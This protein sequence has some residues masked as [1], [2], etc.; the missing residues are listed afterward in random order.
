MEI[1]VQQI[2]HHWIWLGNVF[3]NG[4]VQG[5][6][7]SSAYINIIHLCIHIYLNISIHPSIYIYIYLSIHLSIYISLWCFKTYIIWNLSLYHFVLGTYMW[8]YMCIYVYLNTN[9]FTYLCV[10]KYVFILLQLVS[11]FSHSCQ[12][13]IKLF[14][15]KMSLIPQKDKVKLDAWTT[16]SMLS[17]VK[18]KTH[19]NLGSHVALVWVWQIFA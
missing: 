5:I 13:R 16:K 18:M 8:F 15:N 19:K 9:T 17:F 7:I 12:I 10:A 1:F 14:R 3:F 6:G 4:W 11:L 2:C